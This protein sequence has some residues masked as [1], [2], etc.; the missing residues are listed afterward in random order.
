MD[1]GYVVAMGIGVGGTSGT[2]ESTVPELVEIRVHGVGDHDYFSALGLPAAE[3]LN[4]WTF[5]ASPPP[6]PLHRL[7]IVNWS[8]SNRQYT[9]GV[10]W[11]AAFPFTLVNVAGRMS[12]SG[13]QQSAL[14][15]SLVALAGVLLTLAQLTWIVVLA[16][17][18]LRYVPLAANGPLLSTA[19]V[20]FATAALGGWLVARQR[21]LPEDNGASP[22]LLWVHFV[23][24]VAFG[25]LLAWYRPAQLPYREW[26][27]TS[28]PAAT[29]GAGTEHVERLDA[30]GAWVLLSTVLVMIVAAVLLCPYW[31]GSR[32]RRPERAP[33]AIAGGLLVLSI[34]LLH[35]TTALVRMA[36]EAVLGYLDSLFGPAK[37]HALGYADRALMA[38]DDPALVV[39]NR[40]D[41]YPLLGFM[42]MLGLLL[43]A[44]A[45]TLSSRVPSLGGLFSGPV[46][47]AKWWPQLLA[48]VP[49]LL[50]RAL[51]AGAL[52]AAPLSTLIIVNAEAHED[53][54]WFS[55]GTVLLHV[56][57]A[58]VLLTAVLGQLSRVREVMG[59]VA[60]M[61]GFW[62]VR[63]H[64]L[65]G[66]SYRMP[67]IAGIGAEIERYRASDVVLVGHSQGA[68]LCAWLVSGHGANGVGPRVHLVTSGAPL[69]SV[70]ATLF[71]A[72]FGEEFFTDVAHSVASWK[73]FWRATDPIGTPVPA[74]DNEEL[75]DPRPGQPLMGH[76]NYWADEAQQ[77]YI[78]SRR[79]ALS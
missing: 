40:L 26:P 46:E 23:P 9:R 65:A 78:A 17:T 38:Y 74:A 47:R 68:V 5:V 51:P 62:P 45:W 71:P 77:A 32:H 42:L 59:K 16:E 64:P 25:L 73:N 34:V 31:F 57:A 6:I 30:M 76:H 21:R 14:L 8:R 15:S 79:P 50:P 7:R 52:I 29:L 44:A 72:Y 53:S 48:S 35:A 27:S 58:A 39:D 37:V 70:Y 54:F 61:A 12:P 55:L 66:V 2:P 28:T 69:K 33:M 13:P 24:L 43:A 22:L 20:L 75:P 60:D 4:S 49:F 11:Y 10:M 3:Q 18:V 1:G 19:V 41:L 56:A 63:D 36:L 67:V